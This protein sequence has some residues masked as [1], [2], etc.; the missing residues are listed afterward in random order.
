MS[1]AWM[2]H[3]ARRGKR[4]RTVP[5]PET[6]AQSSVTNSFSTGSAARSSLQVSAPTFTVKSMAVFVPWGQPK[7]RSE[8]PSTNPLRVRWFM[9]LS[10]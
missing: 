10:S 4:M 2:F 9:I 3:Q 5:S 7:S 6:F 8:S 1:R